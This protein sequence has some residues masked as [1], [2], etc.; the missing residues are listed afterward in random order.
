MGT[1]RGD[2]NIKLRTKNGV[3]YIE[4][5]RAEEICNE[6]AKKTGYTA[7][8]E[9]QKCKVYESPERTPKTVR[10]ILSEFA[11]ETESIV[12]VQVVLGKGKIPG[13]CGK[14]V[15]DENNK[16]LEPRATIKKTDHLPEVDAY[17]QEKGH[18]KPYKNKNPAEM[19]R[20]RQVGRT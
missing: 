14:C 17:V 20:N 11:K 16:T 6:L 5:E 9:G 7:R 19:D 3:P 18:I 13:P 2:A 12:A 10:Q 1:R 15:V 8:A 4:D